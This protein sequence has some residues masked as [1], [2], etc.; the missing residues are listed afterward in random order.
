VD[1]KLETPIKELS[2][3]DKRKLERQAK[4]AA[5]QAKKYAKRTKNL[6]EIASQK[7]QELKEEQEQQNKKPSPPII[8]TEHKKINI[9][10]KETVVVEQVLAKKKII[11]EEKSE[12]LKPQEVMSKIKF[13]AANIPIFN[14]KIRGVKTSAENQFNK[15]LFAPQP[16]LV[17]SA[18]KTS[19]NDAE[20]MLWNK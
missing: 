14:D 10:N 1:E 11:K 6:D 4:K 12:P 9:V 19:L 13:T 17:Q 16:T 20:N 15:H 2:K 8:K 3:R 5:Q 7:T 18:M